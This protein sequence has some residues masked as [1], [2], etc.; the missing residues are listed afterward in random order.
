ML[1]ISLSTSGCLGC[2]GVFVMMCQN[3]VRSS[4]LCGSV[5]HG[6]AA[7]TA[8]P[9]SMNWVGA[10]VGSALCV[11]LGSSY[12]PGTFA[13]IGS[14]LPEVL[15]MMNC[16]FDESHAAPSANARRPLRR[17]PAGMPVASARRPT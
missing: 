1:P 10:I 6:S 13:L 3:A 2:T 4:T 12:V 14:P 16:A 17:M 7:R 8:A 11:M 5:D 15:R 9:P